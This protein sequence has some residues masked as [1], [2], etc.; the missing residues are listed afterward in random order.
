LKKYFVTIGLIAGALFNAAAQADTG[1]SVGLGTAGLGLHLSAAV[2]DKLNARFGV[3]ALNYSFNDTSSSVNYDFKLKLQTFDALLD[4]FPMEGKFRITGGVAYN[5]S[6]IDGTAKPNGNGTYTFNGQT[7]NNSDIGSV[8]GNIKFRTAAPY[9]GVGWGNPVAKDKGW[10]FSSD[11]G[12]LFQGSPNATLTAT[13]GATASSAPGGC[14][15]LQ[16]NV[17]AQQASL[18]D[19]MSSYKYYPIVRIAVTYKF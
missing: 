8:N 1:V 12:V 15:T 3:N 16:S 2:S 5:G 7:Y 17:A 18:N 4:W 11:V 9:L 6:K 10:G 13:C 19:T 14:A